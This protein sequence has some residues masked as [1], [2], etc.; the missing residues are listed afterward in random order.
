LCNFNCYG[1]MVTQLTTFVSL[2]SCNNSITLKMAVIAAETCWWE[3]CEYNT[4]NTEV[5]LLVIYIRALEL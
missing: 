2:Y 3:Q 5:H 4:I 1:V